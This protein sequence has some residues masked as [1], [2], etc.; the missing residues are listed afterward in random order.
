MCGITGYF[1]Y[2]NNEVISNSSTIDSMRDTLVLRGPDGKGSF[3][4]EK[5]AFAHTRLSIIDLS[6]ENSQ[7]FLDNTNRYLITFNGEIYNYIEIKNQLL[8]LGHTFRTTG[9]TEVIIEAYK[10]WGEDCSKKLNGIW[11]FAIFDLQTNKMFASRDHLGVKP[12]CYA[13]IDGT[14]IFGSEIKAILE[15]PKYI[16]MPNYEALWH[17]MSC[18]VVP[19]PLTAFKNIYRMAPG[20]NM[21]AEPGK[22][23]KIYK[24]WNLQ[25]VFSQPADTRGEAIIKQ[26]LEELIQDSIRMQLRADV[27]VGSFL[28]GGVDST[29]ITYFAKRQLDSMHTFSMI[30]GDG[31]IGAAFDENIYSQECADA[32]GTTHHKN[33][34]SGEDIKQR[35][36]E[37]TRIYDE[38]C[39][40]AIP[41]YY[42]SKMARK[43]VKVAFG[44]IGPDEA[45]GGYGRFKTVKSIEQHKFYQ[46]S[47]PTH[48][49][50]FFTS[51]KIFMPS[52]QYLYNQTSEARP[53]DFINWMCLQDVNFYMRD[54]LLR[55]VDCMSMAHGLEVRVP[56]CDYR[57]IERSATLPGNLKVNFQ[58]EASF[59]TKYIIKK[60]TDPYVPKS[61]C[62]R[63]KMGFSLPMEGYLDDGGPL[64]SLLHE[65]LTK[66]NI[67]KRGVFKWST[68][69]SFLSQNIRGRPCNIPGHT[70][71]P[72][73]YDWATT[74]AL[75]SILQVEL[76]FQEYFDK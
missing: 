68:V 23:L 24:Y 42:V 33:M 38:P 44:G 22:S 59:Q 15:H 25:D 32:I 51:D 1:N 43:H 72:W 65:C 19:E 47:F 17:F 53:T 8:S 63:Q 30:C 3:F 54:D 58:A 52:Y 56:L 21:V 71:Y 12:F 29:L 39:A 49:A 57:I 46:F 5:I 50:S 27:P 45:F 37:F 34:F 69:E 7:P 31:A 6:S 61:V 26:E 14:L 74:Y 48:Q 41:N 76:W 13:D 75:W 9:D 35:V 67:E 18:R 60:I 73:R 10:E 16:K 11:A 64:S 2:N 20:S 28:S 66:E 4:K 36:R 70:K 40:T 55:Y 62:R